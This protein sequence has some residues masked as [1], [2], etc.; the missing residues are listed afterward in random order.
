MRGDG[1]LFVASSLWAVVYFTI[2]PALR[3]LCGVGTIRAGGGGGGVRLPLWAGF[4]RYSLEEAEGR[5]LRR[6][7]NSEILLQ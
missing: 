6:R 5:S 7:R 2:E 4:R 1:M 3:S